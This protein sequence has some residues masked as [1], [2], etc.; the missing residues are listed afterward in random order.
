M[1][2]DMQN[3]DLE[4]R[5][6]VQLH[7]RMDRKLHDKLCNLAVMGKRSLNKQVLYMIEAQMGRSASSIDNN[8]LKASDL[9]SVIDSM[10]AKDMS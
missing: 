4:E 8:K 10:I 7:L 3:N 6:N 1:E 5:E 2:I 9:N